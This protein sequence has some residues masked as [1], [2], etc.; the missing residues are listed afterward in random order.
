MYGKNLWFFKT[1]M[2]RYQSLTSHIRLQLRK[3][4]GVGLYGLDFLI[5]SDF[6]FGSLEVKIF[7]DNY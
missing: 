7:Q 1:Y 4:K 6:N 2:F 3:L 5:F